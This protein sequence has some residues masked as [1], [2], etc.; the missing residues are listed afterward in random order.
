MSCVQKQ[1]EIFETDSLNDLYDAML[2]HTNS[3]TFKYQ[4]DFDSPRK[5]EKLSLESLILTD[6][7]S[8]LKLRVEP[9]EG[10]NA[11]ESSLERL[12]RVFL[13]PDGQTEVLD[14]KYYIEI[15]EGTYYILRDISPERV[16]QEYKIFVEEYTGHVYISTSEAISSIKPR[17]DVYG[18]FGQELKITKNGIVQ[19]PGEKSEL[20]L[21]F[22]LELVKINGSYGCKIQY[23]IENSPAYKAGLMPNDVIIKVNGEDFEDVERFFYL[24]ERAKESKRV[25]FTVYRDSQILDFAV[26]LEENILGT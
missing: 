9:I 14:G 13:F 19:E 26:E 8:V 6:K 22:P 2:R 25:A 12:E 7:D 5:G 10:N 24:V 3:E 23:V 1:E 17:G 18:G 11:R 15:P 4:L 16:L 21:L 20:G